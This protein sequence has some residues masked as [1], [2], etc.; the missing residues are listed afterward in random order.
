MVLLIDKKRP[1]LC[2]TLIRHI[3]SNTLSYG[4]FVS[5]ICNP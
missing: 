1:C 3:L 4:F 2:H 5:P